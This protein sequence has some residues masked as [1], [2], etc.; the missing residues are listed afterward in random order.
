VKDAENGVNGEASHTLEGLFDALA[1]EAARHDHITVD[2]ILERLGHRSYGPLLLLPS[3]LAIFP[4]IGALPGVSYGMAFLVLFIAIQ[5][6]LSKSKLW[7]PQRLK[8]IRFGADVFRTGV[9]KAR[10]LLRWLDRFIIERFAIMLRPPWPNLIAWLC[11]LLGVLM[12]LYAAVPGGVVIPG[13]AVALLGL[14]LT[15]HDGLVVGLGVLAAGAAIG[16]TMWLV[17]L[18][19]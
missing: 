8:G 11:V 6:A 4:V 12:V 18:L 17:S 16:G 7:L 13:V 15:T 3:L 10:P 19:V 14:G 5:F 9:D 2:A 1:E